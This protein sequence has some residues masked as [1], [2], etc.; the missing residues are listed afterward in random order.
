MQLHPAVQLLDD[1]LIKS[2]GSCTDHAAVA[3]PHGGVNMS[4]AYRVFSD[5]H[6]AYFVTWTLVDWLYLFDKES[7]RQ[8]IL[9]SLNY[10]RTEKKTQLNAFVI[11]SSHLHA[12]LW[13]KIGINL[14]DVTRDFKRHTSRKISQEAERQSATDFLNVFENARIKNRA[15][16]VSKYQVWQEG[17]HPEAIFTEKFAR[18]KMDYIHMNPV[19]AGLVQSPEQWLYSSARAY[20][21]GEETYPPIDILVTG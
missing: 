7:Y 13:P 15:Q 8:I 5:T 11:M 18:Q 14:S 6:Y 17:S 9:D 16:D 20:I 4:R 2:R 19:R 12:I 1:Q 10:L 3:L 21:L